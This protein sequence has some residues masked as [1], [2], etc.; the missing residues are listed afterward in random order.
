MTLAAYRLGL[1]AGLLLAIG[2]A[3]AQAQVLSVQP[4]PGLWKSEGKMLINGQDIFATMRKAQA[5]MLKNLPAEQRAQMAA[6]MQGQGPHGQNLD[7]LTPEEARQLRDPQALLAKM[8]KETP[9]CRYQI[10]QISGNTLGLKGRCNDPE[11]YSGDI[12]G[13]YTAHSDTEG[14]SSF[15]GNGR[16]PQA[17]QV[18]G[19][20]PSGDGRY[21]FSMESRQSWVG[22]NCPKQP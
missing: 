10:T 9:Q 8:H 15:K 20:K 21:Q 1:M 16:F 14:S 18:P 22:P 7:C 13:S 5:E 6:M 11:G 3:A 2:T 17:A 4:R 19:I 12:E